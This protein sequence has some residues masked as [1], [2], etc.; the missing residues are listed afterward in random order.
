LPDQSP[1]A[2]VEPRVV[3][4]Q[5]GDYAEGN[6]DKRQGTFVAGDLITEDQTHN[7]AGLLNPYLGLRAFTA[8]ER[9]IFAGRE[10]I[11]QAL[12]NR[13]SSNDGD[14]L[15]FIVGASGSGKSSLARAGL[16]P[17]LAEH[18]GARGHDI[19]LRI[20]DHPGHTPASMLARILEGFQTPTA[21]RAIRR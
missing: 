17:A 2:R 13:L 15:L 20:I 5:G 10:R 19:V 12:V 14:R 1:R 7:V 6:I 21:A 9:D 4:I 3:N 8:A 11:V 16:L 18:L